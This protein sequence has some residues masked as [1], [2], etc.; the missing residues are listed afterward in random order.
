V[1][2]A[3]S[4]PDNLFEAAEKLARR[5]G[6]SRSE[7]Y[8]RAVTDFLQQQGGDV[9]REALDRVYAKKANRELDPLVKAAG[10]HILSD[11]DW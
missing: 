7:L 6:I 9:V 8:Q 10:E 2:T 11:D 4:I 5:L 3:I 1:K